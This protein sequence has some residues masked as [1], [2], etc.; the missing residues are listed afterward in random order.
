MLGSS[1]HHS[2]A[3]R[4][5]GFTLI[6]LLVVIAIIAVLIALLLPAVQ[7]AREAARRTQCKNN[8]K[9]LGLALHNYHDTYNVF[10]SASTGAGSGCSFGCVGPQYARI[11]A[12][13]ALL[14][15]IDQAP[16]YANIQSVG[17]N[18]SPWDSGFAG[19]KV[20]LT[21]LQCPTSPPHYQSSNQYSFGQS[22]YAFCAGDSFHTNIRDP[23]GMFSYQSSVRMRDMVDG[24]SNT[25]AVSERAY[26][27]SDKDI[28]NM[29]NGYGSSPADCAAYYST[30]TGYGASPVTNTGLRWND[31][32]S[33]FSS[34]STML[35]P[36]KAQ[37][38]GG[39]DEGDGYYT[40][41]SR[42]SGGVHAL[43]ADGS[44]RFISE[45]ID[46]GTQ[47]TPPV[48]SGPS[49]YGVWGA[50]GSKQGGEVLGDF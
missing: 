23:R 45:N 12:A 9:Q 36:N 47:T 41:S 50:L 6:E 8:L 17:I 19:W 24:A 26:P 22:N 1:R 49:P 32:G 15:G 7:Q 48:T 38:Y 31:G 43:L 27:S 13:V 29:H 37:C 14:P 3:T 10:P 16:L 40:A 35:P 28:Y 42:H 34:F 39:S 11:S 21:A 44:V 18:Y 33:S 20:R 25:I 5:R 46:A 30:A 4:K 2:A